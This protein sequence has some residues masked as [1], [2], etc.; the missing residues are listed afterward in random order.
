MP[1]PVISEIKYLGG[2]PL[3]FLE[4]R[5]P[6]DY[7]DP[8][9]L[10]LVIYDLSHNGST[11][12]SPAA[13]DVY[14]ITSVGN[15]YTE[16][17][18]SDG[19]DDDGVLH[20]TIG[21]SENG[22]NIRLHMQDAVGLYNV[23]TGETY[24]LYN[25]S[26][27]SY[28]VSTASGD[29]FAG[30]VAELLDTTGQVSGVTSLERQANGD[31]TL[32]TTPEPGSSYICFTEGTQILTTGGNRAVEDLRIG[33]EVVTKDAGAQKIRWIGRKD[34]MGLDLSGQ[35][36]QPITIKAHAFGQGVPSCDTKVSP[37]HAILN[38]HWKASLFFGDAEVL[39]TAKSLLNADYAYR[40]T[41]ASVSY[42]HILLDR[43][44]LVQANGLW[45]ESLYL[46]SECMKMLSPVCRSQIFNMFPQLGGDISGYGQTVRQQV[47]PDV[48]ALL[49]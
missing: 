1:D 30:Q 14:N 27:A 37:N 20:Y 42:F 36:N 24:G 4:V 5:V 31:Y 16:D 11:S 8:A 13:A 22:T 6:D 39:T 46:G 33:D 44:N 34:L 38:T 19:N 41:V 10:R 12:A 49:I 40:S 7:P 29:P 3:D 25:W 35:S 23:V 47:K 45:A 28:T 18:D 15:L 26:G 48:G 17:V 9:N 2:G 21:Q 32:Q 43:H